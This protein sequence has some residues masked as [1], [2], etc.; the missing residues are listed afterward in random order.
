MVFRQCDQRSFW[1]SV[2]T[3]AH[4]MW[5]N[6]LFKKLRDC[7]GQISYRNKGAHSGLH[8]NVSTFSALSLVVLKAIITINVY[9]TFIL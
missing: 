9:F 2:V 6:E 8:K 4:C 5:E 7:Y 3:A 1:V